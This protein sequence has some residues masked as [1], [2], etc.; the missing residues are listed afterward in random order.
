MG[1]NVSA[2]MHRFHAHQCIYI[3]IDYLN[4]LFH[5][6]LIN[7]SFLLNVSFSSLLTASYKL[8]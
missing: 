2:V 6:D 8:S 3:V 4:A 1:M 7:L 5:P